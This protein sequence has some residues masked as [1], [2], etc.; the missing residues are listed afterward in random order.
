MRSVAVLFA[1]A[2]GVSCADRPVAPPELHLGLQVCEECA[3][4][5]SDA[6]VAAAMI[7]DEGSGGHRELLF[8]DLGCLLAYAGKH[9]EATIVAR[10]VRDYGGERWLELESASYLRSAAIPTPMRY[11]IVAFDSWERAEAAR[12]ERGGEVLRPEALR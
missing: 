9:A 5:V 4:A 7:V 6:R 2:L 10:Y 12:A 11:G 3:M 8:D 1:C